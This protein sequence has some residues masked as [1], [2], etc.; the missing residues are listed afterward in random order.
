MNGFQKMFRNHYKYDLFTRNISSK[1]DEVQESPFDQQSYQEINSA[2]LAH[3]D[4]LR[5]DLGNKS[6]LDVGSGQGDLAQYLINRGSEVVCI[7]A[8]TKNIDQLR[9]K[10]PHLVAH[11]ADVEVSKLNTFGY[12][13]IVFCYGLLYHLENPIAALR[14][15]KSVCKQ[16][17][18]LETMICDHQMP[19]TT[20]VDEGF[21]PTQAMRGLGNR[22]SP[23]FLAMTLNR[24]GFPFV[25]IPKKVPNHPQFDF[26]WKNNFEWI[27]NGHPLRSIFVAST[28]KLT[29]S[30][31]I[32]LNFK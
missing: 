14:N 8:R 2:R 21:S 20:L 10:Y 17:L 6:V 4:T 31:L 11:V 27:R 22:P 7:D 9:I 24:I 30:E 25:Y 12:F 32:E 19:I 5:L 29:N 16:L 1:N 28:T 3:L 15:I 23:S 26:I 13:D 18:L